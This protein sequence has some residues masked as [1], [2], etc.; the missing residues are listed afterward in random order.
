[1]KMISIDT[2]QARL[3]FS[4]GAECRSKRVWT[5]ALFH[6]GDQ[7]VVCMGYGDTYEEAVCYC[8]RSYRSDMRNLRA[9]KK[10][11]FRQLE[12]ARMAEGHIPPYHIEER[13]NDF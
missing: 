13:D 7:E 9:A 6:H 1:M 8:V 3:L 12:I 4:F 5:A 10:R 11:L 2:Y